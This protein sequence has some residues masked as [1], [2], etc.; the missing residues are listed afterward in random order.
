MTNYSFVPSVEITLIKN[1]Q[2][3]RDALKKLDLIESI[4]E[5]GNYIKYNLDKLREYIS[6]QLVFA[7]KKNSTELYSQKPLRYC[8]K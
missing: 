4:S 7:E 6:F 8:K 3:T 1:D 2:P 5:N